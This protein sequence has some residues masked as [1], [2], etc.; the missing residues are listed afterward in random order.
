MVF[1]ITSAKKIEFVADSC[2]RLIQSPD[3]F[4]K[5]S[6]FQKTLDVNCYNYY[7]VVSSPAITKE[8]LQRY[9]TAIDSAGVFDEAHSQSEHVQ[10]LSKSWLAMIAADPLSSVQRQAKECNT[11]ILKTVVGNVD[12]RSVGPVFKESLRYMS[13]CFG[14]ALSTS[15]AQRTRIMSEFDRR[16]WEVGNATVHAELAGLNVTASQ[17]QL[18]AYRTEYRQDLIQ[19]FQT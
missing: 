1:C 2:T 12:V 13:E 8:L 14:D 16:I 18:M 17:R 4:S 11:H 15:K 10:L 5:V 9:Q 6:N 7:N 19:N 3:S